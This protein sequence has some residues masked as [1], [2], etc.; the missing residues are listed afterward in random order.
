MDTGRSKLVRFGVF[1]VDLAERE[2]RKRGAR[3]KLQDQPFRV[4]E[5][6]LE[7][8]GE[9]VTREELKDRLWAQDEFVEFD[10]SLNTAVQKIRQALGDS[11]ENPRFL[12]TIPR[13]GYRFVAPVEVAQ[14][15]LQAA[16][17][18]PGMDRRSV[19]ILAAAAVVALTLWLWNSPEAEIERPYRRFAFAVSSVP[20]ISVSP[21]GRYIAYQVGA[22]PSGRLWL[23]DLHGNE[24]H[25]IE[26]A[27]G[28]RRAPFWSPDSRY[29]GFWSVDEFKLKKVA[30]AGE[31]I[32]DLC[33][34]EAYGGGTWSPD[35]STIW[36]SGASE[37]IYEVPAEGG[38]PIL[39]LET[40][41]AD[42]AFR[43]PHFLPNTAGLS[44]LLVTIERSDG[45]HVALHDLDSGRTTILAAGQ[46]PAYAAS[47]HI[48]YATSAQQIWA[49]PFLLDKSTAIGEPM[50]VERRG[51]QPTFAEPDSLIF[52]DIVPGYSQL[53]WRDRNGR[54]VGVVGRPEPRTIHPY[55]SRDGDR[56]VVATRAEDGSAD[57]WVHDLTTDRAVRATTQGQAD[58]ATFGPGAQEITHSAGGDI[59]ISR[60]DGVGSPR[61]LVPSPPHVL[62]YEWSRTGEYLLYGAFTG[63]GVDIRYLKAKPDGNGYESAPFADSEA[64]ETGPD[65]SPDGRFV[66]FQSDRS[67]RSEIY[68]KPF[69]D[70]GWQRVI[71]ADGG[72]GPRWSADGTEI[73]YAQDDSTLMSVRVRT[74]PEFA[75][76]TPRVLFEQEGAFSGRA[77]KYD[78]APD[79]KRFILSETVEEQRNRIRVV[80]NPL[81]RPDM[82]E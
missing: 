25:E 54:K 14:A 47:G 18:W 72:R 50:L 67:G 16:S 8:P 73:F 79:G 48:Y 22:G 11:A 5:A 31:S 65:F 45:S 58:R 37:E 81:A 57:Y 3:L 61:V 9:I 69:P 19:A 7:K 32:E 71:S 49:L 59:R 26:G 23:Q 43:D 68:V 78:I 10:K 13:T 29:I 63:A 38:E 82:D 41:D 51:E 17:P 40:S 80:Q 21:N 76:G 12:E 6:L 27:R 15:D 36:F 44:G 74:E 39:R 46:D 70:G 34:T 60:A 30:L 33:S 55:I 1:E 4:L 28:A 20:Y 53:T 56:L 77:Q 42:L 2:L 75:A 66:V 52:V 62:P 24:P 64:D 35:G